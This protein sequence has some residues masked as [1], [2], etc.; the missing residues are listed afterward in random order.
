[1]RSR[2]FKKIGLIGV[3]CL[4]T[5]GGIYAQG[6]KPVPAA[7]AAGEQPDLAFDVPLYTGT[8]YPAPREVKYEDTFIPLT[9]VGIVTGE[10]VAKEGGHVAVLRERLERY[11]AACE[12]VPDCKG[13]FDAF[14]C[15]GEG[16]VA[17]ALSA[18]TPPDKPEAFLIASARKDGKPVV[19]LKGKDKLGLLWAVTAFNQLVKKTQG[20]P[21]A[22]L[23]KVVDYPCA[24]GKR[25][26]T[27][28]DNWF[29]VN[30]LRPN[31]VVD[32][33]ARQMF[34]RANGTWRKDSQANGKAWRAAIDKTA[35]LLNPLGIEWYDCAAPEYSTDEKDP[36][37]NLQIRSKSEEDFRILLELAMYCAGHG[38]NFGLLYDDFRFPIHPDDKRDFG[39]A[40]EADVY[41]LSKLFNEVHAK[42]PKFKLLFCPPFYWGPLSDVGDS[43]GE[44][45]DDYLKAIGKLPKGVEIFW[46]GPYV[47]SSETDPAHMRWITEIIQR[48]PVYWQNTCGIL[49][50]EFDTEPI[51]VWKSWYSEQFFND[52]SFY[53]YNFGGYLLNMT[54]FD[55]LWNY[56]AYDPELSIKNAALKIVG[57]SAY[58]KLAEFYKHLEWFDPY[59]SAPNSLAARNVE[60]LKQKTAELAQLAKEVDAVLPPGSRKWLSYGGSAGR[61]LY[62]KNL[63]ALP[64]LKELGELDDKVKESAIKAT[65]VNP[66]NAIIL[67]PG[68]FTVKRPATTYGWGKA[69]PRFVCWVNGQKTDGY[70][71]M[72]A[73]FKTPGG[74][75]PS[76]DYEL[77]LCGLNHNR[78]PP[79]KIKIT[80]NGKV[81]FEGEN[82][83]QPEAWV[84]H[85]F[86]VPAGFFT[87]Q[88]NTFTIAN[89]E[90]SDTVWGPPWF[91]FHYAVLRPAK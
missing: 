88:E 77:I 26:Y 23:A 37:K 17:K 62:L 19:I 31:I 67:T 63:L 38:G 50:G 59:G 54:L 16:P 1:M 82:P 91:M 69:E 7:V 18:E 34:G 71:V 81:I 52:L 86:K 41:F 55:A 75:A 84:T 3:A 15:L 85:T 89:L 12:V 83:F 9:R 51:K 61:E 53:T 10:G 72:S 21:L 79:C 76:T 44:S 49:H 39:S 20:M 13:Q 87:T 29:A 2:M 33:K 11:G 56:A 80:L 65:G 24:P 90:D 40:R 66:A 36:V 22:R 27:G 64:N 58:P 45:R 47:R 57:E 78:Q 74:Q 32:R 35:A 6:P 4:L 42:Y 5:V 73:V 60:T 28:S 68:T 46:T 25:A 8:I 14:I 30:C 70:G 43:Y 48:K